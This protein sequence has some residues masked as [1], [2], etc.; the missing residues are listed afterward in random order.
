MVSDGL[1]KAKDVLLLTSILEIAS[2]QECKENWR[3]VN[4]VIVLNDQ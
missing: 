3:E 1:T 4:A 2:F